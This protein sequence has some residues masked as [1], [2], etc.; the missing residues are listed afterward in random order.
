MGT[1]GLRITRGEFIKTYA[2]IGF[3]VD[4]DETDADGICFVRSDDSLMFFHPVYRGEVYLD[5][6]LVDLVQMANTQNANPKELQDGFLNALA[7]IRPDVVD[8]FIE[9]SRPSA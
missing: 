6:A 3:V 9:I 1:T 5:V 2:A 8:L 4:D 7:D